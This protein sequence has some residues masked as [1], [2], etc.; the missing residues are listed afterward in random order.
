[1]YIAHLDSFWGAL[2]LPPHLQKIYFI[3]K[4]LH[5]NS[6]IYSAGKPSLIFAL[7]YFYFLNRHI[8][9]KRTTHLPYR[10]EP[11]STGKETCEYVL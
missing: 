3:F 8:I 11:V 6:I 4:F 1:M 5:F 9:T 2:H 7:N 10:T